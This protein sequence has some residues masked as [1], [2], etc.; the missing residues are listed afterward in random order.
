M[1]PPMHSMGPLSTFT[2]VSFVPIL[3]AP[4]LVVS[5][6]LLRIDIHNDIGYAKNGTGC[7]TTGVAVPDFLMNGI[8]VTGWLNE[9][10]WRIVV[11]TS[12]W[13]I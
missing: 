6:R 9:E 12:A 10:V 1:M 3:F 5:G 11:R 7:G 4:P 8:C 13:R 2:A